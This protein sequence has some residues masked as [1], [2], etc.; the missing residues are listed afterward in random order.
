[1]HRDAA[2]LLADQLAF[3]G[4]QAGP[5][6]EVERPHA[7]HDRARAPHCTSGA[8]EDREEAVAARVDL[9]ATKTRQ[10][11]PH[12]GVVI[13]QNVTPA[14]VAN[15]DGVLRGADDIREENRGE[16]P[17]GLSRLARSR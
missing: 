9:A 1:M 4:V 7:L 16:Y 15:L 8:V 3:T 11:T 10:L 13:L 17:V 6:L 14:T 5:D 2:D 12:H